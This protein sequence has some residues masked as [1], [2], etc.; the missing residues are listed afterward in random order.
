MIVGAT[1]ACVRHASTLDDVR[2]YEPPL[3]RPATLYLLDQIFEEKSQYL[4]SERVRELEFLIDSWQIYV[5]DFETD[6]H[7]SLASDKGLRNV[8]SKDEL[9]Q[10]FLFPRRPV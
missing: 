1:I 9:L 6:N 4:P 8:H 10:W 2:S 7:R 5:C 3:R